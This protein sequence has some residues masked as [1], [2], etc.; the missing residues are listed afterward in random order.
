[1]LGYF[2]ITRDTYTASVPEPLDA[3]VFGTI[4]EG[5]DLDAVLADI[6]EAIVGRRP[7][8]RCDDREGFIG[9]IADQ[10]TFFVNFI[11]H[12]AAAV[13]HHRPDRRRQHAVAVDQRADPRA[14]PAPGRRA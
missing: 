3:F 8:S 10:I 6:D 5:A 7:T 11:T 12:H 9:S 1:M 4:D 14:R 13:D 2:T